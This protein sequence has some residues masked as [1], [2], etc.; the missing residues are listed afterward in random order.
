[1]PENP[2]APASPR[3]TYRHGDLKRAL[4]DAA[5][6]LAR[7]AGP[8]AVTLR[9][10]TRRSGVVPT[11]AYRH[12]SN[13]Q[14]LVDEVR[15]VGMAGIAQ[16]MRKQMARAG[17]GLLGAERA[18]ARFRALGCGYVLYALKEPGL[19]RTGF[20]ANTYD[21]SVAITQ[22]LLQAGLGDP[23]M[24]LQEALVDLAETGTLAADK[25]HDAAFLAWSGVHGMALLMLDGP[26]R[27]APAKEKKALIDGVV[28]MIEKGLTST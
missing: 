10:A 14:A 6:A 5:V 19:F 24:V 3:G 20:S 13:H 8:V 2:A 21:L 26:L 22:Q 25:R 17:R 16:S 15:K 18:R 27:D 7:E 1:M 28:A 23:F 9:E 12:F 11:A 4:V